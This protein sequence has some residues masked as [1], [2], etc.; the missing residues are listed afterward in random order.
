MDHIQTELEEVQCD[1]VFA[2]R[3]VENWM[4][5]D[6]NTIKQKKYINSRAKQRN[7]D[8]THGVNELKR[9]FPKQVSYSKTK[10]GVE[11]LGIV[12]E[13]SASVNSPS[14]ARFKSFALS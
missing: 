2:D 13:D 5:A 7:Y 9:L 12:K 3:M 14:F 10:H 11:L 1:V 6:I 4:L 8:G